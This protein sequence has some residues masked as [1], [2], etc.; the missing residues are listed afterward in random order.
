MS[1]ETKVMI[2][3]LVLVVAGLIGLFAVF[4]RSNSGSSGGKAD[5]STLVR[6]SSHKLGSGK[7]TVVEFGDYQCPACEAAY[8]T[9][10]KLQSQYD[11]KITFVF[12]NY[13]L[14]QHQ[15]AKIAAEAAEAAGA[16]G[17]FWE[18]HDKLYDVQSEW[19]SSAN[20]LDKFT[21]YAK[22]LGLDVDKFKAAVQAN[23]FN[24]VIQADTNDGNT[25]QVPGTPTFFIN[26]QPTSDFQEAT[27]KA[28]IDN[29]LKS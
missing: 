2:G 18:M 26:G 10:K 1:K 24:D 9:T 7:V 20:P 13:P 14:Q 17:K 29:A 27:L 22:E 6:D 21:V 28:A 15:Y 25:V 8:P 4:N 12:R 3:I 19:V 23:Q 16:Q 5:S 11:G